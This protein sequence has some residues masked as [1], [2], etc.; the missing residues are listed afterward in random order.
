MFFLHFLK[1]ITPFRRSLFVPPLSLGSPL[2][3]TAIKVSLKTFLK[4]S[5]VNVFLM[6][7]GPQKTAI[8]VMKK[9]EIKTFTRGVH[10]KQTR[11]SFFVGESSMK[12]L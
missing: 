2:H 12:V 6:V 8:F 1:L 11:A 3:L 10:R 5:F 7:Q 4:F 9:N